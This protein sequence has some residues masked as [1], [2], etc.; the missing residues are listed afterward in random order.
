MH[1]LAETTRYNKREERIIKN[2]QTSIG[3]RAEIV[4]EQGAGQ[5]T[6]PFSLHK[7]EAMLSLLSSE[8][9]KIAKLGDGA[10]P[11]HFGEESPTASRHSASAAQSQV[12]A[13]ENSS[14]VQ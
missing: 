4:T 14:G 9:T 7:T 2:A 5:T 12:E 8:Q 3:G 6:I 1:A 11:E 10:S 13:L